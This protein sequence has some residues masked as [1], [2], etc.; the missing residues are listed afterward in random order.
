VKPSAEGRN[1]KRPS[2]ERERGFILLEALVALILMTMTLLLFSGSLDFGRRSLQAGRTL[3]QF[4]ESQAGLD[5]LSAWLEMA[6]PITQPGAD[7]P[8]QVLFDGRP[9]RL[10]FTTLSNGD[11]L[12]GGI[13][14]L[15]LAVER[16]GRTNALVFESASLSPGRHAPAGDSGQGQVLL[17]HVRD[18]ELAYFG[19]R[20]DGQPAAWYSEWRDADR[21]P[22]L[23]GLRATIDLGARTRRIDSVFS[24][25]TE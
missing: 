17:R 13:L 22:R 19:S 18:F 11:L 15:A 16:S 6:I 10:S 21:L 3:D 24:V 7:K 23:V 5:A 2:A 1:A 25:R 8:G 12:P 4:I 9:N 14:W 20:A